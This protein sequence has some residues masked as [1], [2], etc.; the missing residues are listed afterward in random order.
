ML[1]T[2]KRKEIS[3]KW[4]AMFNAF[5]REANELK[6]RGDEN[7]EEETR[8]IQGIKDGKIGV[9]EATALNKKVQLRRRT[10]RKQI[11]RERIQRMYYQR[12]NWEFKVSMFDGWEENKRLDELEAFEVHGDFTR[13]AEDTEAEQ[14]AKQHREMQEN[15]G[16]LRD[17]QNIEGV[18]DDDEEGLMDLYMSFLGPAMQDGDSEDEESESQFEDDDD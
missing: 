10:N 16:F 3:F 11:R 14:L 18:R 5:F 15:I 4:E 13:C 17:M 12:C 2:G 1:T 6:K 9:T 8:N 7:L